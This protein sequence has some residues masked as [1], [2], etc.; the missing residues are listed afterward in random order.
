ASQGTNLDIT[1]AYITQSVQ[2]S[3]G[4]VPLVAGRDGLVRVFA[5]GNALDT[6]APPVRVRIY[7]GGNLVHTEVVAASTATVPIDPDEASI[8]STWNVQLPGSLIQ[9][10]ASM[11]VDIDPSN[12]VTETNESDNTYPA[13]GT[14]LALDVRTLPVLRARLVPVLQEPNGLLGDV[15]PTTAESYITT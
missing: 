7:Q 11:L 8:T 9:P 4:S 3:D 5:R 6:E 13:T 1:G 10:G 14:P 15:T 12:V 2:R